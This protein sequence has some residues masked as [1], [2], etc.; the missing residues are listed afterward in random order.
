MRWKTLKP[1]PI[2]QALPQSPL[3]Y[4]S[5]YNIIYCYEHLENIDEAIAVLNEV[6][7][8]HP[9]FEVAWHQL[10]KIYTRRTAIKKPCP[11]VIL[12]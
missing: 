7:E 1:H 2:F 9:Y 10:G 12:L 8:E 4:Q 11:L 6:L 5:L 3:D